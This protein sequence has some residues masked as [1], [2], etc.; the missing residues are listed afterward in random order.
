MTEPLSIRSE[1]ALS[2]PALRQYRQWAGQHDPG[3]ATRLG[4]GRP[5][6]GAGWRPRT[7]Q[8]IEGEPRDRNFC[9]KPVQPGSSYC[10]EHH[11]RCWHAPGQTEN[12]EG[13]DGDG[14]TGEEDGGR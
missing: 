2:G 3:S 12:G 11:A 14:E 4:G 5:L 9:G 8:F 13:A 7:C 10:P 6:R 1:S